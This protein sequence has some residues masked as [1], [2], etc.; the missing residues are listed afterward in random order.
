MPE[1]FELWALTEEGV[2]KVHPYARFR[3]PSEFREDNFNTHFFNARLFQILFLGHRAVN[4][5][6]EF[7]DVVCTTQ[8]VGSRVASWIP[9]L[10]VHSWVTYHT[11]IPTNVSTIT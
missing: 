11:M 2:C 6:V 5:S 10:F 8:H 4:E 9:N 1:A 7:L 3:L